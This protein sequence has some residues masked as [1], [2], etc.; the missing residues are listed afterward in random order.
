LNIIGTDPVASI[1]AADRKKARTGRAWERKEV[2]PEKV[3]GLGLSN[4][5]HQESLDLRL[6]K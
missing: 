3:A 5:E 4:M 2:V 1:L 6:E